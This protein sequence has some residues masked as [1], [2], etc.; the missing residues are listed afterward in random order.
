MNK[1]IKILVALVMTFSLTCAVRYAYA[2]DAKAGEAL[3]N[4]KCKTCHGATGVA[5]PAIA[6]M[7][8]V[9]M[10]PLGGADVQKLSDAQ[11]AAISKN[12]KGKM[13]PVAGL[14]DAQISDVVAFQRTLKK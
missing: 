5:N 8:N 13:K 11:L 10:K 3:Y 7:L 2:A 9:E 14:T 12:G 6:K 4:A 1:S